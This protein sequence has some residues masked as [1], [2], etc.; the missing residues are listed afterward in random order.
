MGNRVPFTPNSWCAVCRHLWDAKRAGVVLGGT[1]LRSEPLLIVPTASAD[2]ACEYLMLC[3]ACMKEHL[4][5]PR[6]AVSHVVRMVPGAKY[7]KYTDEE[8]EAAGLPREIHTKS[9]GE[10]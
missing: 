6:N 8:R 3:E 5:D 4:K 9:E 10:S 2:V 1:L 7:K